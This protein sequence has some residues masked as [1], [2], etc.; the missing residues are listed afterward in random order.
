M[1]RFIAFILFAVAFLALPIVAA[2]AQTAPSAVDAVTCMGYSF[3]PWTPPLDWHAS[4]HERT[5]ESFSVPLA[6]GGRGRA[7]ATTYLTTP[8]T[9]LLFPPWWPVGVS[10][11]LPARALSPGDTV[12]GRA[13]ALV[14]NGFVTPSRAAVRAWLVPCGAQRG[15][16]SSRA[17][18]GV[19]TAATPA[20]RIPTG[21]WR[22]TSTCLAH[23]GRCGEDSVV[24]RITAIAGASDSASLAPSTIKAH[25][26]RSTGELRC[27]YDLFSAI[28]SCDAPEGVLRLA[29]RGSELGGRLTRK[30]GVD[31]S[32][33][34][35]RRA[36][37]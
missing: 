9:M 14:A 18:A 22:G 2:R 6:P 19:A 1:Q 26:E 28:L 8:G 31:L 16:S 37:R 20:D 36:A 29:V 17:S 33:V 11:A 23:Q 30:D 24:Y 25:G 4:G 5:P 27:R 7:A 21:T 32:Y 12:E 10:V 3:G 35:V 15:D 13:T 34:H